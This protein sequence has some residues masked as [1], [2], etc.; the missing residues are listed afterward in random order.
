M[1]KTLATTRA[2]IVS[3]AATLAA[4]M[5]NQNGFANAVRQQVQQLPAVAMTRSATNTTSSVNTVMAVPGGLPSSPKRSAQPAG[6]TTAAPGINT[7]GTPGKPSAVRALFGVDKPG[8]P[9]N[10][11]SQPGATA[12]KSPVTYTQA[13]M[14]KTKVVTS[15]M[16]TFAAK[17][18]NRTT[19]A[20]PGTPKMQTKIQGPSGS[21]ANANAGGNKSLNL[22][23][24]SGKSE[25]QPLPIKT[26]TVP[27]GLQGAGLNRSASIPSSSAVTA[28]AQAARALT[29]APPEYSPF[30]NLFSQLQERV[31][32]GKKEDTMNFASVAAAGVVPPPDRP[33]SSVN[34]SPAPRPQESQSD[35]S[36]MSKAPGYKAPGQRT[37]SPHMIEAEPSKA[38]GY[39]GS[40]SPQHSQ[41]Q[42]QLSQAQLQD[43]NEPLKSP[44][45]PSL[46]GMGSVGGGNMGNMAPVLSDNF[47]VP[48]P[49]IHDFSDPARLPGYRP[50]MQSGPQANM[51]PRSASSTP[52]LHHHQGHGGQSPKPSDL[53]MAQLVAGVRDEYSMPNQPMTLPRIESTL[54]PNAPDFTS[55]R[56]EFNPRDF[57]SRAAFLQQQQLALMQQAGIPPPPHNTQGPPNTAMPPPPPGASSVSGASRGSSGQ[58]Q[59]QQQDMRVPPPS[60]PPPS[61]MMNQQN[62]NFNSLLQAGAASL[63]LPP[64]GAIPDFSSN[65]IATGSSGGG[66]GGFLSPAMMGA[67]G[68][69]PTTGGSVQ[70]Q[71]SPALQ[72]HHNGGGSMPGSQHATPSKG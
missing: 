69:I 20:N 41:H 60:G 58:G 54:N 66:L 7:T 25:P 30:N 34:P 63:V 31:I 39:K 3:T 47:R 9:A 72:Q 15:T 56:G 16:P 32:G 57:G 23:Q 1:S 51:S 4:M 67:T 6:A 55:S 12:V 10:K 50:G 64:G 71:M 53:L 49:F 45:F 40:F 14:A 43:L 33:S 61:A 38:P 24:N 42:Q 13:S 18:E 36:L 19:P 2:A 68:T 5:P 27:T 28:A 26:S 17:V 65:G 37:T 29:S 22:S 70:R 46:G 21:T 62:L 59:Q 48:P 35:P 44:N 11:S 8:V 52:G